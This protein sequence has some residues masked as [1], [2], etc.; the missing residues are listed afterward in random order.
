M[1]SFLLKWN[2][3]IEAVAYCIPFRIRHQIIILNTSIIQTI[4]QIFMYLFPEPHQSR[5][6]QSLYFL[7]QTPQ[8]RTSVC[9]LLIM[10]KYVHIY[11]TFTCPN[12]YI[13]KHNKEIEKNSF[14]PT[15]EHIEFSRSCTYKISQKICPFNCTSGETYPNLYHIISQLISRINY[16]KMHD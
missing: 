13:F 5:V 8:L 1:F 6:N 15:E 3:S 2:R 4:L 14:P 11:D 12:T 7:S 16:G 9:L 10:L